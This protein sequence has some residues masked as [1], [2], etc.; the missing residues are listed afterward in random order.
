MRRKNKQFNS[1]SYIHLYNISEDKGVVFYC[2]KDYLV[3]LSIFNYYAQVYH[4]DI[5]SM[6]I[7][8]NHFHLLIKPSTKIRVSHFMQTATSV[9]SRMYNE[10]Y[11]RKGQL[12]K[13]SYGY[14]QKYGAKHI[15]TAI[16]YILNNPVEKKKVEKVEDYRWNFISYADSNHPFSQPLNLHRARM[17]LRQSIKSFDSYRISNN[18][19]TY[20]YLNKLF[21]KLNS[22]EKEQMIDYIISEYKIVDFSA[23]LSFYDNQYSKALLATNSNT[24]TDP[25]L[26]EEFDN[27]SDLTYN[28]IYSKIQKMGYDWKEVVFDMNK[29]S[30]EFG[31][32][33]NEVWHGTKALPIHVNRFFHLQ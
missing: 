8:M 28:C 31:D 20:N 12:F 2:V 32:L 6:C 11:G 25:D 19:L 33:I 27:S 3:F 30:K 7:M 24:G 10:Q 4:I 18:F 16:S 17:A 26:S 13:K 14:S 9:F 5:V 29:T 1:Q 23:C 15:K 21:S 22:T